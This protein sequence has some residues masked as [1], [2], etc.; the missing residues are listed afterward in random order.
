MINSSALLSTKKLNM[1]NTSTLIHQDLKHIWHPCSQ[2]KDFE[3]DPPL[4]IQSAKGGYLYTDKGKLIDGISSWWCKSLGH[5]H[6]KVIDAIQQQ[7]SLFEHVMTAN[8]THPL[9][10][11]LGIKLAS[12]T[13]KEHLFFASDG[14]SSVEIAM[15]L[16]LHAQQVSGNPH[17]SEFMALKNGYHGETFGT[18]GISD[19]GLY[20]KPYQAVNISCHFINDIPYLNQ[21][22][23]P[24][25][26][27]CSSHW[28]AV[29]AQIEPIKDKI[30]ALVLEP[31][32]QGA[33]GMRIYSADFLKR[34]AVWA[35]QNQIYLIA[36]EIMT[37]IGRTGTWLACQHIGIEPDLICLSKGLTSGSIPF[38][39]VMIDKDIFDLFYGKES[40]LHSHTYSGNPLGVAAA[41]ATIKTIEQEGLL[42]NVTTL[43]KQMIELMRGISLH[44]GQ[45]MNVRGLG[46]VVA[47]DLIPTSN[48]TIAKD[49]QRIALCKG[50]LIRPIGN[51]LYWLPPLN[52][53]KN[54]IGNL[55]NITLESIHEAY[56]K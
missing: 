11:E 26:S 7:L 51:T 1:V 54:I 22:H 36:D 42:N 18:L 46:G 8:T 44:T 35:K 32:I 6:P 50:A 10:A 41:L 17:K 13:G 24:L 45:L 28:E 4:V 25:W 15:K 23:D 19:L 27:D 34:L 29:L 20:K 2:M 21:R 49:I 40:F 56:K 31:L 39:C 5:G 14:S 33:A 16:A 52:S 9:M 3:T 48:R 53:D 55:A 38:S 43:E 30:C 47:A 12:I 37:G